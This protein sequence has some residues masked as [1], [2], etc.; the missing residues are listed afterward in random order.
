MHLLSLPSATTVLS[1]MAFTHL[2][3]GTALQRRDVPQ[4]NFYADQ[5]CTS[6]QY[7]GTW[8]GPSDFITADVDGVTY[9]TAPS[10]ESTWIGP[11]QH[12]RYG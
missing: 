7:A 10:R 3:V 6:A 5:F 4:A 9:P 2:A 1:L 11:M 8:L 12:P